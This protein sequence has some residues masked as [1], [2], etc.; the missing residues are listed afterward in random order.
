[1]SADRTMAQAIL[2]NTPA[3]PDAYWDCFGSIL[4]DRYHPL[5]LQCSA[6]LAAL[7]RDEAR[8]QSGEDPDLPLGQ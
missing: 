2:D 1:M 6:E 4:R 8:K 3:T 5:H 7:S